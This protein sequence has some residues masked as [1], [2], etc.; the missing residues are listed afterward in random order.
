MILVTPLFSSYSRIHGVALCTEGGNDFISYGC[1]P[2]LGV[3]L[4]ETLVI[5]LVIENREGNT[6]SYCGYPVI[7]V[8][9][10]YLYPRPECPLGNTY[11]KEVIC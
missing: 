6:F 10:Y 2:K 3:L 11:N 1:L 5:V 8:I 7:C 9:G 4:Q